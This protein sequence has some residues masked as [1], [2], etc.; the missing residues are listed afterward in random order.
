MTTNAPT[1]LS[2]LVHRFMTC[3]GKYD[4]EDVSLILKRYTA[5]KLADECIEEW[6][7]TTPRP[8]LIAAFEHFIDARPDM[9]FSDEELRDS[10]RDYQNE[11]KADDRREQRAFGLW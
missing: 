9:V 7:V 8:I 1:A 2:N 6:E 4:S 10:R 11:L 3:E 5:E